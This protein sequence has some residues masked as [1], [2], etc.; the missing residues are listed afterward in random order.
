MSSPDG[1]AVTDETEGAEFCAAPTG[2]AAH[3]MATRAIK[4]INF[5]KIVSRLIEF[6]L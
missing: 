6:F 5:A 1:A 4:K 2:V 3:K